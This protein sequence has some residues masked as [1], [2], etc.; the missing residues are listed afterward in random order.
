MLAGKPDGVLKGTDIKTFNAK[1]PDLPDNVVIGD[2]Y[3]I[4][5]LHLLE[6]KTGG[7]D[8]VIQING[9]LGKRKHYRPYLQV[10]AEANNT[11]HGE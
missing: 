8:D 10:F 2:M 6:I 3:N 11:T 9:L 1:H 5:P 4:S 7:G